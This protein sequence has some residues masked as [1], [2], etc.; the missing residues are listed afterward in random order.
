MRHEFESG[1]RLISF[2]DV[3]AAAPRRADSSAAPRGGVVLL[4]H[5][6]PLEADMWEPQL[7]AV[8]AGWRFVA[9][10]FRGFGRSAPDPVA[11]TGAHAADTPT[12]DDYARDVLAL[13]DHLQ[14]PEAVVCGLSMGGYVAFALCRLAPG[15]V[16]GVV[17]A[18]TRADAD[19]PAARAG[20]EQM[21]A[22]LAR[23]GVHPVADGLIPRLLGRTTLASRPAVADRVRRMAHAQPVEA[24]APAITRLMG[25]PD[26]TPLLSGLTCP[27]LV[28]AGEEDEITGPDVARAMH[29][30]IPG[31]ELTLVARAGHLSNLERPAA[32]NEALDR[33]LAGRIESA[34]R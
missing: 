10:D 19:S 9:P 31:A 2:L 15:R 7:V 21:Q 8:P 5:A 23:D 16:R 29:A 20:R 22:T 12:I 17:L 30:G 18:D 11:A 24:V 25:R 1:G 28:L 33:F 14:L 32:F 26:S 4:L 27:A 6:F 13:L 34:G 3:A